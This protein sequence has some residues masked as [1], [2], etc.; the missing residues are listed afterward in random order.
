LPCFAFSDI[1]LE[2]QVEPIFEALSQCAALHPDPNV[3]GADDPDW[4]EESA[5]GFSTFDGTNEEELSEVGK[6][7]SDLTSSARFQPY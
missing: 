1:L 7:R 2:Q 3:T 4:L 5:S 6:V